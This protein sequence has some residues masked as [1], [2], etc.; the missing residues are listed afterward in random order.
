MIITNNFMDTAIANPNQY[1]ITCIR[2]F[3]LLPNQRNSILGTITKNICV[4]GYDDVTGWSNLQGIVF[5]GS[6]GDSGWATGVIENNILS[7]EL[8]PGIWID[9]VVGI[10]IRKN[11]NVAFRPSSPV[12]PRSAL[13][14]IGNATEFVGP[15][16]GTFSMNIN[17]AVLGVASGI[18]QSA[19]PTLAL[20]L[21]AYNGAFSTFVETSSA[22][23]MPH[24]P[25]SV[26][27]L[28]SPKNGYFNQNGSPG[29]VD[30]AGNWNSA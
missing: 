12:A 14:N 24:D 4:N 21:T 6:R 27:Q 23:Q 2:H 19:N 1:N 5:Q 9:N 18:T 11:T 15:A 7:G 25:A 26:M 28:V 13:L 3:G 16:R 8:G 30:T 10:S 29:A 20:S 22:A 17:N